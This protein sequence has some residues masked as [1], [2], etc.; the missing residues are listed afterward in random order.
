MAHKAKLKKPV[1][2]GNAHSKVAFKG[3]AMLKGANQPRRAALGRGLSALMGTPSV[4]V[5]IE[6]PAVEAPKGEPVTL[7][8]P[9]DP[10]KTILFLPLSQVI[11]NEN[12]PRK[13]FKEEE[14]KEL[15]DSIRETGLLQPI[16]VRKKAGEGEEELYEIIAGERRYR[17]A[18]IAG[19]TRVPAIMKEI[20]DKDA[21]A[22]S[23]VENIQRADLNPIEEALAFQRLIDTY[24]ETQASVAQTVGK[25]RV[26]V[27]NTLRLLK[28]DPEVQ[29]LISTGKISA[30]H[31]RALLMLENPVRQR[32]LAKKVIDEALSVRALER[33]VQERTTPDAN[34]KVA[35]KTPLQLKLE[36]S[37]QELEERCRRGLG[38]KVA[39]NLASEGQGDLKISFFS[40]AE[41]ENI[42]E[43]LGV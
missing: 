1:M 7:E 10:E 29:S 11:P 40:A 18:K 34:S 39:V 30:G 14:L 16:I 31:G 41:L 5:S 35:A 9:I 24:G 42:L 25:D 36:R 8:A 2:K 28:L 6:E 3:K 12:Q 38:T 43:R 22:L 20:S 23:I 26:S 27:T 13:E 32:A 15:G 19:L 4:R 37:S 17:A 33:M 21:F